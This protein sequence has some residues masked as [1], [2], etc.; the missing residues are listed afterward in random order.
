MDLKERFE[1]FDLVDTFSRVDSSHLLDIYIG[2]DQDAKK[3]LFILSDSEP[4]IVEPT[5]FINVRMGKRKDGRWGLS[6]TIADNQYVDMFLHFCNDIIESS[7]FLTTKYKCCDFVCE[8]YLKWQ[9]M[10]TRTNEGLLSPSEIKG[11]VGELFFLKEKLIPDL[12]EAKAIA[13]WIGPRN[14]A[15]DFVFSNTW[16]EVKSAVSGAED[17]SISSIEQLDAS[18]GGEL[19]VI[20]LDATSSTDDNKVSLNQ[21]YNDIFDSLASG[22]MRIAFS[23]VLLSHGYYPRAEYDDYSYR[24]NKLSRYTVNT[25]FPCLRRQNLPSAIIAAKYNLSLPAIKAFER[26]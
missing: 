14:A 1:H 23:T 4:P 24:L 3:T 10:L 25:S 12:G 21:L 17:V 22:K 26:E 7:R 20:F 11:L 13:S 8:R 15:Q 9:E 6:F 18:T 2:I 19:V 16:Y 5:K